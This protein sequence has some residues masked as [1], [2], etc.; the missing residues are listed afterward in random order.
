MKAKTETSENDAA[1]ERSTPDNWEAELHTIFQSLGLVSK[2]QNLGRAGAKGGLPPPF[3]FGVLA[4]PI[5]NNPY[6]QYIT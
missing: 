3:Y 6:H 5:S 1:E 2:V 4:P